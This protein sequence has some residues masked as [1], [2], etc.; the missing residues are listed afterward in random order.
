MQL[1]YNKEESS[2]LKHCHSENDHLTVNG[3]ALNIMH[4]K[5]ESQKMPVLCC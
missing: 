5:E 3:I 4:S 2:H 1:R